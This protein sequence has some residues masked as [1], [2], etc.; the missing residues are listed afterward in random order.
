MKIIKEKNADFLNY[1]AKMRRELE[2][3]PTILVKAE[4]TPIM[5]MKI[6]ISQK[7]YEQ[8]IGCETEL[9][10]LKMALSKIKD[11]DLGA[12]VKLFDIKR[13]QNNE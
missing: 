6:E 12:L 11:Y 3:S 5:D 10:M 1:M 13:G 4:S 9:K 7:R 2:N 8:L